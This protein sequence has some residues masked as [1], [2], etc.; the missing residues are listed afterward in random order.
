MEQL[1]NQSK[2]PSPRSPAAEMIQLKLVFWGPGESGKTTNYLQLKDRYKGLQS[3]KGF[4]VETT[5]GRTLWNDSVFFSFDFQHDK[6]YQIVLQLVTCTGQERFLSTR[7]Y[8]VQGADGVIFVADSNPT[9]LESN[10][11]SYEELIAFAREY[12]IPILIQ[13]NKRDLPNAISLQQFKRTLKLPQTTRDAL[14]H[15]IVYETIATQGEGVYSVFNDMVEKL[16]LRY[17]TS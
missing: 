4:S 12:R 13:L 10:L 2:S 16:L 15:Q 8:V 7:E 3:S 14:G 11:R 5:N 6:C 1:K 9:R 17:F